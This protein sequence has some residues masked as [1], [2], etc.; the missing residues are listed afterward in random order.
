[1]SGITVDLAAAR[2]ALRA[3][4]PRTVAL[5][6]SIPN[7]DVPMPGSEWTVGEAAAHLI[8]G[9]VDYSEHARGVKECYS[10]N[11][12][13]RTPTERTRSHRRSLAAMVQQDGDK[14]DAKLQ[15]GVGA[16]LDATAGRAAED[17]LPWHSGRSLSCAAMTCLLIGEQLL[18]GYDMAGALSV[19]WPI[20]T[21]PARLAVQAVL[22]LLPALV[23]GETAKGVNATY[24]LAVDGEPRVMAR[25]RDG[26]GSIAPSE[27]GAVD[28]SLSGDPVA[29]LVALYGRVA[30]EELL[31]MGRVKVTD[32]DAT[33]GAGFKRLLRNP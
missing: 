13:E 32:G 9:A 22:P 21:E 6:A 7:L 27:N 4:T 18:H 19:E 26:I 10:I 8:I 3:L 20:E 33:L 15:L 2:G 25:F 29:W 5:V 1:M 17:L 24:E 14:L 28:C 12:T 31:W 23:D 11:P 16:F 30:W